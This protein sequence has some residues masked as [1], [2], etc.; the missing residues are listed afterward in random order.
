MPIAKTLSVKDI[1][2]RDVICVHAEDI[3]TK[4]HEIFEMHE[5][6]HL[7]VLDNHE[8]IVGI[9]SRTDLERISAGMSMFKLNKKE[10]YNEALYRSLRAKEIMT[11][12]PECLDRAATLESAI[13]EFKDN[14]FRALPVVLGQHVVGIITPY[15]IM[16]YFAEHCNC[17]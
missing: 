10:E 15:D 4:V 9:I 5:I 3:V 1:M 17:T 11:P 6:H 16:L 13:T 14:K 12:D 2:T 7:P 8:N